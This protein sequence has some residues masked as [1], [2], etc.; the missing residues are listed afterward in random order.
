LFPAGGQVGGQGNSTYF[1]SVNFSV[2]LI[3]LAH[4]FAHRH[5]LSPLYTKGG[6]PMPAPQGLICATIQDAWASS[7][8]AKQNATS[9]SRFFLKK[10]AVII[11]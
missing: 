3:L 10:P 8:F 11:A 9:P 5:C 4:F 1:F 6:R 7:N 2:K